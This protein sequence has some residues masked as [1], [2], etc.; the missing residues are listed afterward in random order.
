M[1]QLADAPHRRYNI[2][3]GEWIL[4]SPHR[5]KRPWQGQVEKSAAEERPAYDEKCYLCP[6]NERAG[7]VKNPNYDSVFVFTN[8][9]S[10]LLPE[11]DE[12]SLNDDGLLVAESER[13][14]CHVIYKVLAPQLLI[15]LRPH[16]YDFSYLRQFHLRKR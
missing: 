6:G 15:F 8:D 13:G 9:F 7:G 10:A 16:I 5:A 2:L 4:V 12:S 11:G 3:T 14:L 1:K